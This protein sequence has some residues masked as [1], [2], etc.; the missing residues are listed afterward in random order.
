M[1]QIHAIL[2]IIVCHWIFDFLY[3]RSS[4]AEG[5]SKNMRCLLKHT[6]L[7]SI[8]WVIPMLFL[9][10]QWYIFVIVTFIL[11]TITDYFTSKKVSDKFAKKEFG[12]ETLPNT[13]AFSW[14]G[15]DQVLHYIQLFVTYLIL[16]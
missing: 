6:S 8:L 5:K 3:Q 10:K 16:Q 12:T 14:I 9:L 1:I 7:Y 4:W 15:F 13:G 11:H 2:T